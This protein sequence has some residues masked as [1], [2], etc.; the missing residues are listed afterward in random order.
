MYVGTNKSGED[1]RQGGYKID[2][3][4]RKVKS[5]VLRFNIVH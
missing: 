1:Y 5:T 3:G 4:T 2:G